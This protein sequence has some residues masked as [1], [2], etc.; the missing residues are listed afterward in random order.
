MNSKNKLPKICTD[1]CEHCL[2]IETGDFL[3]E[4]I[5]EITIEDWKPKICPCPK[6]RK[7]E[8]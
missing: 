7:V 2:Y 8:E 4:I 3:C 1:I 5:N 6:K